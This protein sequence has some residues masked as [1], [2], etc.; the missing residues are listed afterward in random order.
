ME[1]CIRMSNHRLFKIPQE[2]I[3]QGQMLIIR[4]QKDNFGLGL[5]WSGEHA[6]K[7]ILC[8]KNLMISSSDEK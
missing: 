6:V 8:N 3:V 7:A 5:L 4:A 1:T 2:V